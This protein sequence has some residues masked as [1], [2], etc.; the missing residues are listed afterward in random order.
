MPILAVKTPLLGVS[1]TKS[2][3]M[4]SENENAGF[5]ILTLAFFLYSG[6]SL[7]NEFY[8]SVKE[9]LS[10]TYSVFVRSMMLFI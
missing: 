3:F 1:N 9:Q 2:C 5:G 8:D 7:F 6:Y 10:N 4:Q